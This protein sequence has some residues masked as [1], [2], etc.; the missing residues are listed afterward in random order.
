MKEQLD[1]YI[2]QVKERHERCAGNEAMTKASLIAPLFV[3]LGWD[4]ANPTE[5]IPEYRADFGKG[6]KSANPV[7]WAFSIPPAFSFIVEAKEAS[8]KLK[9][10]AEQLGMYFA[11]ASVKLGIFSNGVQWKFYT[12]LDKENIMDKEPFLSWDILNDDPIP[13]DFLTL[14]QKS[15]FQWQLIRTFADGGRKQNMLLDALTKL[16]EPSDDFI[17]L[18]I[19]EIET[20]NLVA[21]VYNEWRPILANALQEW[22]KVKSLTMALERPHRDE[23]K[24][25]GVGKAKL[26]KGKTCPA[27]GA[28]GLGY[29]TRICKC[30]HEFSSASDTAEETPGQE[31]SGIEP[32]LPFITKKDVS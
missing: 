9:M 22:V 26:F 12:D 21:K 7:D 2:K 1:Q 24:S 18:A 30:G 23:S 32:T 6:E 19:N 31:P 17:K 29:R 16:L 13:F 28:I 10:Y 8:K 11:K 15:Q 20:R 25:V 14:L 3:L 4:M 5:C 27:C